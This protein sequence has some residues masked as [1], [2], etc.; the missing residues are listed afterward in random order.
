MV[1]QNMVGEDIN[2]HR[3]ITQAWK[4]ISVYDTEE[5]RLFFIEEYLRARKEGTEYDRAVAHAHAMLYIA[6]QIW[7]PKK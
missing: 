4:E 3:M 7:R 5:E 1:E 6:K 2:D